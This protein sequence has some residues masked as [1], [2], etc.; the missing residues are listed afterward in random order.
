MI[1]ENKLSVRDIWAAWCFY[2]IHNDRG[3]FYGILLQ[4][5]ANLQVIYI[6]LQLTDN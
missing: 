3:W 1:L 2:T 5:T 4:F 6:L